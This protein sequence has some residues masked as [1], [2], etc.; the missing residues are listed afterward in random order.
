MRTVSVLGG[1]LA[2]PAIASVD[3]FALTVA[4]A[5]FVALARF[6]VNVLWVVGVAAVAGVI[7]AL[8]G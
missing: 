3:P 1:P 4:V 5:G 7:R 2:V 6:R 8:V